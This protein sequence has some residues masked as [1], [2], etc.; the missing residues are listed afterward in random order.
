MPP[1]VLSKYGDERSLLN[2]WWYDP[3]TVSELKAAMSNGDIMPPRPVTIDFD[4]AL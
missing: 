1:C 4:S 2:Y 3:E